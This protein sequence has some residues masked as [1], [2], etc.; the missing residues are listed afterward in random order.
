MLFLARHASFSSMDNIFGV[1]TSNNI[2]G[3][4]RLSV[5]PRPAS[6]LL[7]WNPIFSTC[8]N[9]D[10]S[11]V[12]STCLTPMSFGLANQLTC[13]HQRVLV[14]KDSRMA[15]SGLEHS[16]VNSMTKSAGTNPLMAV[17]DL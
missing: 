10:P 3:Q 2:V 17:F 9:M 11:I 4:G 13:R 5:M 6:L 16:R 1:Q 15:S 12:N 8:S 7:V 14:F